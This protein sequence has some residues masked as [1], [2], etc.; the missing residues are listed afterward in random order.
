M[1]DLLELGAW[2]IAFWWLAFTIAAAA[3]W[4]VFGGQHRRQTADLQVGWLLWHW[5]TGGQLETSRT[6]PGL[7]DSEATPAARAARRG[8]VAAARTTAAV[9]AGAVWYVHAGAPRGTAPGTVIGMGGICAAVAAAATLGIVHATCE[10]AHYLQWVRPLHLAVHHLLG[11]DDG[12][13]PGSYITIPRD[14]AETGVV[15]GF[16]PGFDL[17]DTHC[18]AVENVIR[19]KL[20]LG[21]VVTTWV[22]AGRHQYLM[23]RTKDP[24]PEWAFYRDPAIRALVA[25]AKPTAPVVGVTRGGK[26]VT[27]DLESESP[28]VMLSAGSGAGK[29]ATLRALAA[30]LMANGALVMC[31]DVKRRSHPW[32]Y[33][34]PGV[35]YARDVGEINNVLVKLAA[36]GDKRNRAWDD[37][38]IDDPAPYVGPRIIL[39][40]EEMTATT[41]K[42]RRWWK[43]NRTSSDPTT[44]PAVDALEDIACMGRQAAIHLITVAQMATAKSIGGPETRENFA[45]R[46]MARYTKRAWEMLV[47][48]CTFTPASSHEGWM[49]V[50]VGG[51]ATETQGVFMTEH[52]A[53]ALATAGATAPQ[54]HSIPISQGQHPVAATA[55]VDGELIAP[56]PSVELVS[57][58]QAVETGLI[59]ITLA[60][61]RSCRAR[62]PE[63]PAPV[64][65]EGG[66]DKYDKDRIVRWARNRPRELET[67]NV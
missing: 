46:I 8:T 34:L 22:A 27:V 61:L 50:C 57:L 2:Q 15:V 49:Q 65:R 67:T 24:M 64:V 3:G 13:R 54:R 32:L 52:E 6:F 56:P 45:I 37:V 1:A 39:L 20:D 29:S 19:R 53:R 16:P 14:R 9:A 40:C 31:I 60:N 47:P 17:K 33:G 35:H 42:L 25:Q 38:G 12:K 21:E 51:V 7:D 44:S 10:A 63:F 30:Q 18:Q 41:K 66:T 26:P 4:M 58:R 11:W 48:E 43:A 62:D 23:L 55:P 28:H 36:E 5:F 59:V